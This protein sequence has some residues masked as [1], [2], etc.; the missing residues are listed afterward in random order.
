[1]AEMKALIVRNCVA[2]F[3]LAFA[4]MAA[5]LIF[6]IAHLRE[7][8]LGSDAGLMAGALLTFFLGLTFSAAQIG[9]AVMGLGEE[10]PGGRDDGIRDWA[11]G[12]APELVP[13]R[14]ERGDM[15]GPH[16]RM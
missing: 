12:Q 15:R 13:V 11:F 10:K 14:V 6:D 9:I 16:K 2:G 5:I 4:A 1:M 3:A 7:L 8:L